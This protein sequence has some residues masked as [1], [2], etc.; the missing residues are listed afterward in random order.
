MFMIYIQCK[1]FSTFQKIAIAQHTQY[2]L[3]TQNTLIHNI[4]NYNTLKLVFTSPNNRHK[5]NKSESEIQALQY[6]SSIANCT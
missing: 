2:T 6:L 4:K 1:F 5:N 3:N